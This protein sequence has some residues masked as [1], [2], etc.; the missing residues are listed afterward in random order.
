MPQA[1]PCITAPHT[2]E[3]K[4]GYMYTDTG[5]WDTFRALFP[6]LNL[7]YPEVNSEIQEGMLNHY[8]ESGFFPEWASPATATAWSEIIRHPCS[9]MP[10]ST[11]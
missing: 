11:E 7:F 3:V 4:D 6:L 9:P 5:L 1:S 2:G 8:R 10:I